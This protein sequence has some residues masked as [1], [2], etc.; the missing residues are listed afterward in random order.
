[1]L[2]GIRAVAAGRRYL[3][4]AVTAHVLEERGQERGRA[5]LAP[6]DRALTAREAEVLHL[7]AAG[8]SNKETAARL[9][10]SV[11]TVETHKANAMSR[12]GLCSRTEL[13]EFAHLHGWFESDL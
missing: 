13:V 10:L 4:R 1:L 8:Y 12:L 11:K 3:D 5:A 7:V 6:S 9:A 2:E